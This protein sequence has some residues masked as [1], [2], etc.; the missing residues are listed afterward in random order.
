MHL[1]MIAALTASQG[2]GKK[3]G[4]MIAAAVARARLEAALSDPP[5]GGTNATRAIC[6]VL[7]GLLSHNRVAQGRP[8]V[9]S[10]ASSSRPSA[11]DW[12]RA[13]DALDEALRV[14]TLGF[15]WKTDGRL[16]NLIMQHM[17]LYGVAAMSGRVPM[18]PVEGVPYDMFQLSGQK[19]APL[20][21]S[22]YKHEIL[23]EPS[24]GD[25]RTANDQN[26]TAQVLRLISHVTMQRSPARVGLRGYMASYLYMHPSL[27]DTLQLTAALGTSV[28]RWLHER[29]PRSCHL[30]V[31]VHARRGDKLSHPWEPSA[32]AQFYSAAWGAMAQLLGGGSFCTVIATDDQAWGREL[33]QLIEAQ[34]QRQFHD[35]PQ[36]RGVY[37]STN[38]TPA[39]DWALLRTMNH[40]IISTGSFGWTSA[41]LHGGHVIYRPFK[42]RDAGFRFSRGG[43]PI[44]PTYHVAF[45]GAWWP[46]E[47]VPI[48]F[49]GAYFEQWERCGDWIANITS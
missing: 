25:Q 37:L 38:N 42:L 18:H 34:A 31:G 5:P 30:Y 8:V 44:P 19:V 9:S 43:G 10:C 26:V 7:A 12:H 47:W 46:P 35:H 23:Q 32:G 4:E 24:F 13:N 39:F 14:R 29:T 15:Q 45:P 48:C 6:T 17:A 21:A 16:G 33:V 41:W 28:R 40:S 20:A 27:R 11:A 3:Q 2:S 1:I 22:F 36:Q 49:E